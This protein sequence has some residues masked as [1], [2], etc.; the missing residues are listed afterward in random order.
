MDKAV[1]A[2]STSLGE[3]S[4]AVHKVAA[5]YKKAEE[6]NTIKGPDDQAAAL[7]SALDREQA[8]AQAI[9]PRSPG[10]SRPSA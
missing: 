8:S 5:W 3:V 10:V 1:D 4:S 6:D 7:L 2:V 9:R